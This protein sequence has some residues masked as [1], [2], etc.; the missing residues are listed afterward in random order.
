MALF[1]KAVGSWPLTVR[2]TRLDDIMSGLDL[3]IL[4]MYGFKMIR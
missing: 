4:I 3:W 1:H 2:P